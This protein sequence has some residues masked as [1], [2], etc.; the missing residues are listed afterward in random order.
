MLTFGGESLRS[1]VV[2]YVWGLNLYGGLGVVS[3]RLGVLWGSFLPSYGLGV[4][5]YVWGLYSY[6]WVFFAY[7]WGLNPYAKGLNPYV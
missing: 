7:F 2:S 5:P 1:G 3:L 6:V 4:N